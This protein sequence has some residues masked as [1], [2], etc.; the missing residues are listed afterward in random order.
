MTF[1]AD[2]FADLARTAHDP[3][4]AEKAAALLNGTLDPDTVLGRVLMLDRNESIM[5]ALNTVLDCH[6]VE[7]IT[8]DGC[9]Y[10]VATYLNTG[11]TYC[12]TVVLTEDGEFL[13]T[14]WGDFL[15]DW[16][17]EQAEEFASE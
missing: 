5:E 1:T 11:D 9:I 14:S 10:P 7:A 16:E 17:R 13:L 15:E 2:Q 3:D 12:L 6:G 4:A 8:P